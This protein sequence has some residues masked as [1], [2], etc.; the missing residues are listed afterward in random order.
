M[1]RRIVSIVI[2]AMTLILCAVPATAEPGSSETLYSD[3]LVTS[4]SAVYSLV[5]SDRIAV[6]VPA[7]MTAAE[8]KSQLVSS[9]GVDVIAPDG[10]SVLAD[11]SFVPAGSTL[12]LTEVGIVTD[13]AKIYVMGDVNRDGDINTKDIVLFIRKNVGW[14]VDGFF[15]EYADVSGDGLSATARDG[16]SRLRSPRLP[17][18]SRS[19]EHLPSVSA[20]A[21]IP[22]A[23]F[24]SARAS[25]RSDFTLRRSRGAM[26]SP[27]R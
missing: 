26:G 23:Q 18:K 8:M 24:S 20:R 10:E 21:R 16:M 15:E 3:G 9:R 11:D 25:L 19:P 17:T 2:A 7:K 1:K 14:D 13:R 4:E 6:N 12:Q 5:G 27:F 22:K